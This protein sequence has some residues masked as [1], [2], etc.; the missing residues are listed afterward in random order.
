M[1]LAISQHIENQ[2]LAGGTPRAVFGAFQTADRFTP[3]T[4]RRYGALARHCPLVVAL[5]TGLAIDLG[6]GI[7]GASLAADDRLLGEWTAVVVGTHY[8]GALIA[9]DLGDDGPDAERRFAF[10]VTHDR[11]LVLAAARSL[12]VRVDADPTF[13]ETLTATA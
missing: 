5:G 3:A 10:R 4:R 13:H 8:A 1:L 2:G 7:R 11:D 12:L 6:S 9:R